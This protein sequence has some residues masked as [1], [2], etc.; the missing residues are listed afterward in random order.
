ML[1]ASGKLAQRLALQPKPIAT[2]GIVGLE[3]GDFLLEGVLLH[4]GRANVYPAQWPRWS[5]EGA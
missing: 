2:H 4:L 5:S 1:A 3:G